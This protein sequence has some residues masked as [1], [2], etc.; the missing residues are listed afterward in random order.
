MQEDPLVVQ[1]AVFGVATLDS[2]V[3]SAGA[4]ADCCPMNSATIKK[5]K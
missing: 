2:A 4:R 3:V 5:I 1:Y